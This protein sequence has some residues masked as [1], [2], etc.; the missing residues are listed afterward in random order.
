MYSGLL[1]FIEDD[2]H[3]RNLVN[4]FRF[5]VQITNLSCSRNFLKLDK[6]NKLSLIRCSTSGMDTTSLTFSSGNTKRSSEAIFNRIP[7]DLQW[8]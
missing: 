3:I 5:V 2:L 8:K 6:T 7:F 4:L 1:L